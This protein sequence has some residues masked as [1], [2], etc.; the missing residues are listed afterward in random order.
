MVDGARTTHGIWDQDATTGN[1]LKQKLAGSGYL[2]VIFSSDSL[3]GGV[4]QAYAGYLSWC[5]NYFLTSH[6]ND[7]RKIIPILGGSNS[8]VEA[9]ECLPEKLKSLL[10]DDS[11]LFDFRLPESADD[12]LSLESHWNSCALEVL[13]ELLK[14]ERSDWNSELLQQKHHKNFHLWLVYTALLLVLGWGGFEWYSGSKK[15]VPDSSGVNKNQSD[16]AVAAVV[17]PEES[18]ELTAAA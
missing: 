16:I 10:N 18:A 4:E 17:K 11:L 2:L 7:V 1:D 9:A 8:Q 13:N 15:V 3:I 14:L 12:A 6:H 5:V